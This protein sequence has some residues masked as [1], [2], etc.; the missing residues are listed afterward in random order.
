MGLHLLKKNQ[1]AEGEVVLVPRRNLELRERDEIITVNPCSCKVLLVYDKC[2]CTLLSVSC[3]T[4]F[5]GCLL[6]VGSKC[7]CG[8]AFFFSATDFVDQFLD[9]V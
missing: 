7:Y 2:R 6:T 9:N 3:K 5:G 1:R 8:D 4:R